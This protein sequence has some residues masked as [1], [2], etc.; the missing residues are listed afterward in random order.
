LIRFY[1]SGTKTARQAQ[2]KGNVDFSARVTYDTE[3]GAENTAPT[4]TEEGI[5][6]ETE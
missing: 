2:R 6:Y 3:T 4:T 1:C 5:E